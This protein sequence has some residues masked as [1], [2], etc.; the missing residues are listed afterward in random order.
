M[1]RISASLFLGF[2]LIVFAFHD[3]Y[4]E[5]HGWIGNPEMGF[6]KESMLMTPPMR[7]HV[8]D[9]MAGILNVERLMCPGLEEKQR[10]EIK[11]IKSRVMKEQIKKKAD[12]QI[13][14][15]E[16]KDLLDKDPV[17]MK[18]V[19]EKLKQIETLKAEMQLLLIRARE[20]IKSK[21][22]PDQRNNFKEMLEKNPGMGPSMGGMMPPPLF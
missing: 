22:T 3:S 1:K 7:P 2:W 20:A 5:T 11:E 9:I 10:E 12:R 14:G 6:H 19:E 21:L 18:A 16:L 4:A 8:M 17:N 13:A 15:I